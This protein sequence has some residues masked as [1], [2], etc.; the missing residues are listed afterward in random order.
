M[1]A[2]IWIDAQSDGLQDVASYL[3]GQPGVRYVSATSGHSDVVCEVVLPALD[4]LLSFV[5]TVLGAHPAIRGY[6][7]SHQL[8]TLKR[9]YLDYEPFETGARPAP[10]DAETPGA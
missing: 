6:A 1:E 4:D 5:V 7:V 2:L 8:L 9:G 10:V 3:A